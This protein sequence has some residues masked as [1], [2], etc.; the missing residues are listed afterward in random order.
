MKA[1]LIIA[2]IVMAADFVATTYQNY[3]LKKELKKKNEN[4]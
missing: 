3:L 1:L 4:L 2:T